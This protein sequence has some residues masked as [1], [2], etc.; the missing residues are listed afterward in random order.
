GSRGR[1]RWR[2]VTCCGARVIG[3]C[4]PMRCDGSIIRLRWC[5]GLSF[6]E[7]APERPLRECNLR[8][9]ASECT[10]ED[11]DGFVRSALDPP[12]R[13]Y[14][15]R[16]RPRRRKIYFALVGTGGNSDMI[17]LL[18]RAITCAAIS[19]PKPSTFSFPA[20]TAA[21]TAATS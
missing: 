20:S 5:W 10:H 17:A 11:P 1:G 12:L 7:S 4:R 19:F 16:R 3:A 8:T 21:F 6:S 2:S 15:Q 9:R 18:G 13:E 14:T